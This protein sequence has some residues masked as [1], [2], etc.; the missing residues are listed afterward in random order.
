MRKGA[1]SQTMRRAVVGTLV[2]ALVLAGAAIA[3]APSISLKA[4]RSV[5][6]GARY[7]IKVSGYFNNTEQQGGSAGANVGAVTET[8]GAVKCTK[9]NLLSRKLT[10]QGVAGGPT[11]RKLRAKTQTTPGHFSATEKVKAP[12]SAG[13]Y[14]LCG[15]LLNYP[16]GRVF[17]QTAT[18]HVTVIAPPQHTLTVLLGGSGTGIVY[19]DGAD[20]AYGTEISCGFGDWSSSTECSHSYTD[21]ASVTLE[22]EVPEVF[23]TGGTSFEGWSGACSGTGTCTVTMDAD[24]TVTATFTGSS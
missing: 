8:R 5:A 2:L 17:K 6:A 16:Y 21:G 11:D 7:A 4:P 9:R 24:M 23:G 13:S 3:R 1:L 19:N 15:Y 22:A 14:T 18:A 12:A 10:W 20:G